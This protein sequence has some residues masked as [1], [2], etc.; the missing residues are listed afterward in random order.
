MRWVCCAIVLPLFSLMVGCSS[1]PYEDGYLYLPHPAVLDVP[2]TQP[3]QPPQVSSFV[4]VV[5]IRIADKKLGM[6]ES[7]E[8]RLRLDD[9]GPQAVTFDPRS[10]QLSTGDLLPF[11]PPLIQSP[12]PATL[13]PGE[14]ALVTANFPFPGGK[15]YDDFNLETLQLQWILQVGSQ[16]IP[17][18]A[19]FRQE[20]RRYYYYSYDPYWGVYPYPRGPF[21]GGVV[22]IHRR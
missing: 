15:S 3:A 19:G 11:P 13:T 16:R 6:P 20:Y 22:V 2:P 18:T 5:G 12:A 7:V 4:S 17:Q 1:S 14:S 21:I 9:N 8:V 10:L